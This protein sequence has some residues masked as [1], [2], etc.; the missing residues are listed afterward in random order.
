MNAE[1]IELLIRWG[2]LAV[3]AVVFLMC[4]AIGASRGTYKVLRRLIYVVLY[5]IIVWIFMGQI[6]NAILNINITINGVKGI[7]NFIAYTIE[8]NETIN[9][10]LKYSSDLKSIIIDSPEIIVSPLLFVILILVGLPLSFPIYLIYLLLYNLIARRVFGVEK[11]KRS[12]NGEILRDEKG[13]KIKR[14]KNKK[15]F[16][17]GLLRGVQGVVLICVVL[18]PVNFTNRIYNRAKS[19]AELE[20]NDTICSTNSYLEKYKDIC[21]YFDIYNETIFSK[22]GGENS[23]DELITE[24]LTTIERDGIEISLEKELSNVAI[25]AVLLNDSGIMSLF[26]DG[27]LNLDDM[28][29]SVIKFD[30]LNMLI[31]YLFDSVL[32]SNITETGVKYALNEVLDDKLVDLLKDDDIVSKLEYSNADEIKKELKDVVSVLKFSVEKNL[33]NVIIDNRNNV[34]AIANN[35]NEEDIEVL[36]NKVLS[37]KIL[38]KAMPSVLKAYGEKYGV[39]APDVMSDELNN[40]VAS[41]LSEAIAFVKIM[42]ITKLSDI[43]EGNIVDNLANHLFEEGALKSNSKESLANLLNGLNQSYLFQNVLSTQINKM[44]E[45]KDY[46]IDARVLNYVDSKEA[47]LKELNGVEE[48]YN[49]YKQYKDNDVIDYEGV[50]SLL[51]QMS[52][53]KV[54][55]AALPF[56]YD[57]ILPKMGIEIDSEGLPV[58]DFDGENEDDSKEEFY[59]TWNDELVILK[60]IADAIE[61]LE[62]QSLE[63]IDIDLIKETENIRALS[64]VLGEVYKS[65]LLKDSFVDFMKDTINGFVVD[66]S[67]EF[68]R[69]ELLSIN[70][71]EKWQNE[72]TN[73]NNILSIDFGNEENI[74]S[75]NL[76]TVFNSVGNMQLFNTKKIDI[77]KYAIKQSNFLNESEYNNI[78]WPDGTNQN[79]IDSFWD[80]ETEVL[81]NVVNKK[82]IIK[83]LSSIDPK[84]MDTEE[85]GNLVNEVMKSNILNPIVV[86]K[87]GELLIANDIKDDRDVADSVTNLKNSIRNVNDWEDELTKLQTL[88]NSVENI[89]KTNYEE[90]KNEN[91]Y[92]RSGEEDNY[93]YKQNDEGSYLKFEDEYYLIESS[94]SYNRSGEEGNYIYTQND[95]G[96]YLKISQ[97]KVDEVFTTIESSALLQNSRANLL[98]KAVDTVDIVDAPSDVTIS[99]LSE[100]DY[101]LYNSE[102]DIIVKVSKNKNAFDS[103]STMKL[104]NIDTS[105]IGNLLDTITASMIFKNYVVD[106]IATVFT[107]NDISDDNGSLENLKNNIA[108]VNQQSSWRNELSIIQD[109]LTM[110]KDTFDDRV[111]GKTN[112]KMIFENIEKSIL[113]QDSRASL[114]I[115]AIKTMNIV[116][117]AIPEGE[118]SATLAATIGGV[119]YAQ[120]T[121]ETNV[122]IA[123]AENTSVVDNLSSGIGNFDTT[124]KGY[125]ANLLD[126]MKLSKIFSIKYINTVT[127]VLDTIDAK[128]ANS[129]YT[130]VKTNRADASNNYANIIWANEIELLSI[131]STNINEIST[132]NQTNIT[133]EKSKKISTISTTLD[134]IENSSFLGVTNGQIIANAVISSL[135]NN[136]VT[137]ISKESGKTWTETFTNVL[138]E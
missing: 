16:I 91:K 70:T 126:A 15:R 66:Y 105:E 68:S 55:I 7:R 84:T 53:T 102:R 19:K 64:T 33:D 23:L 74:N 81:I 87:V 38:N 59:D 130:T 13:K 27:K 80:N 121:I 10:V 46:K 52:G 40:E 115:K 101:S 18:L 89:I 39:L 25:S 1:T 61:I 92:E 50:T 94:Y 110:T 2:P 58:I 30:K 107:S 12:E 88:V 29:L 79:E 71:N 83:S 47:W 93:F 123:F 20:E 4:F 97:T 90:I 41:L 124:T 26:K 22:I 135:T 56:T 42:E 138:G 32:V 5:V 14:E 63:E 120:Y 114:L 36:L 9:N 112:I 75:T 48:I 108:S 132:Y 133:S 134:A 86:N 28:D 95:E 78:S 73:I 72:L 82:D 21:K 100:N 96:L 17:G 125:V 128:I 117:V 11:Y 76:T 24:R 3:V 49:L 60:N 122:L 127:S 106:Q 129:G 35:V 119:P 109:M 51:N 113:L 57:Y 65:K 116:D 136:N 103:L 43:I 8:N 54:L 69:D 99:K 45:G 67:V 31:D 37:L 85:I 6:T 118:T 98:L 77:L 104:A 111:D 131:I 62:L 44:L 34:I 137:S